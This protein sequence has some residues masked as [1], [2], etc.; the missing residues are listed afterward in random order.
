MKGS[1]KS[2]TTTSNSIADAKSSPLR[3][4]NARLTWWLSASRPFFRTAAIFFSSSTIKIRI[5]IRTHD[6]RMKHLLRID[7]AAISHSQPH[8][9]PY[10]LQVSRSPLALLYRHAEHPDHPHG[11]VQRVDPHNPQSSA[12]V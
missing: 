11:Y 1:I 9:Q 3:P 12:S 10:G 7:V 4:S 6:I 2:R 8:K 5:T